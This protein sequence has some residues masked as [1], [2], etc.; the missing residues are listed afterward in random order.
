MRR[1]SALRLHSSTA[2]RWA[3][4]TAPTSISAMRSASRPLKGVG[5]YGRKGVL[6]H[7]GL[8]FHATSCCGNAAQH[9]LEI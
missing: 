7:H 8:N 5:R 9:P 4:V 3:M 6:R 1:C 2:D